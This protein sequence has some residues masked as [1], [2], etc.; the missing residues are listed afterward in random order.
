[1]IGLARD[2]TERKQFELELQAAKLLAEDAN[3]A[4]SR[5][6]ADMSHELRTPLNAVIGFS[7]LISR[8]TLGPLGNAGYQEYA[9]E[10]RKGGEHLLELI[11]EVLDHAKASSGRLQLQQ[12][13]SDPR[14]AMDFPI[15]ILPHPAN[16]SS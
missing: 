3:E 9:E 14:S 8:A 16:Q 10:I 12:H 5:F 6:L 2:I 13:L 7:D 1:M 11:N 4:K 15:R